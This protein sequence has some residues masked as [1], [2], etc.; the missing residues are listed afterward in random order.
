MATSTS[1]VYVAIRVRPLNQREE[2]HPICTTVKPQSVTLRLPTKHV[3]FPFDHVYDVASD[4][5]DLYDCG[6]QIVDN[7]YQGYNSCLF[8]YGQTGSG[9]TYTTMGTT[10]KPGLI[11]YICQELF[12]R[13][14]IS[15]EYKKRK[16]IITIC[17]YEIYMEKIRDLLNPKSTNLDVRDSKTRGP[18]VEGLKICHVT[19]FVEL[20]SI[21]NKGIPTRATAATLMNDQ[22]SR[23]HAIVGI[24]FTQIIAD[25][26][27]GTVREIKSKIN[28]IDLAGS[29]CVETA[30]STG[31]TKS[32]AGKIN[33]SLSHLNLVMMHLRERSSMLAVGVATSVVAAG[34]AATATTESLTFMGP[35]GATTVV[36]PRRS[37]APTI[38]VASITPGST[39]APSQSFI[40]FRNSKLTWLLSDSLG[41]NSKTY[42]IA[43]ISPSELNVFETS[44]TL[45]FA[46]QVKGVVLTAKVNEELP[47][48]RNA[49]LIEEK[50]EIEQRLLR[51]V[52][53][54]NSDEIVRIREEHREKIEEITRENHLHQEQLARAQEANV[55]LTREKQAA[56]EREAEA[57][58]LAEE[59]SREKDLA[60]KQH[61]E[62]LRVADVELQRT[63][64]MSFNSHQYEM[65]IT[66]IK[67]VFTN[68]NAQIRQM[69]EAENVRLKQ[70]LEAEN[71]RLRTAFAEERRHLEEENR[72]LQLEVLELNKKMERLEI[73]ATSSSVESVAKLR[74]TNDDLKR[75]ADDESARHRRVVD[76]MKR[77]MELERSEREAE[78]HRLRRQI[79]L[80]STACEV[81][82]D[83]QHD[84]HDPSRDQPRDQPRDQHEQTSEPP[85]E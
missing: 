40:N 67:Q 11:P 45:R 10:E 30:G 9:K 49:A 17:Y 81:P 34:A 39:P 73:H 8:A 84:T 44:S 57:K 48:T 31:R 79:Q 47:E 58:H 43:N 7:A 54:K 62:A 68:E 80:L 78:F 23:S 59:L 51:A 83:Q 15:D 71:E 69:L 19:N 75:A 76:A 65:S 41:G 25:E 70:V 16:Y 61:A 55:Q 64:E 50:I 29:E 77:A 24:T 14:T 82:R 56:L 3:R 1:N 32:E 2:G 21:L 63:K 27:Q 72:R 33:Q 26:S 36:A 74:Q 37:S 42:M 85:F 12:R 46:S 22:S 5:S 13:Q 53:S 35:N 4:Q 38:K 66:H 60:A 20:M 18:Y 28:L 6:D 52:Q